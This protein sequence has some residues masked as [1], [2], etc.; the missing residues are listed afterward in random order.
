MVITSC[1]IEEVMI[2]KII[3]SCG[4]RVEAV[5]S[6]DLND[7]IDS[8]LITISI[9]LL[10]PPVGKLKENEPTVEIKTHKRPH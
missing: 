3:R 5:G 2:G 1:G 4:R 10:K 8:V 6:V 7:Y 9:A